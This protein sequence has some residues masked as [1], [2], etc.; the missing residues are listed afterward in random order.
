MIPKKII[1]NDYVFQNQY[2]I[3]GHYDF[4]INVEYENGKSDDIVRRYSDI[5]YLY[6]TLILKCPGCLIPNIPSKSIWLKINYGNNEQM[7]DRKEG[8]T[9][10]LTY[11]VNHKILKRNKYVINFFSKDYK[12]NDNS[13]NNNHSSNNN[14]DS[15]DDFDFNSNINNENNDDD[16]DKKE[17]NKNNSDDEDIEP[18]QEFI[19]EYNNRK[20]GIV[21]KGK[22]LIGNM[23]NYV[24]SYAG[25]SNNKENE[26]EK[27]N[28]KNN[29]NEQSNLFYKKLSKEDYDF[30]NKKSKELGE[31]FE[32]NEYNEKINRLN[33]GVKNIIQNLEKIS[34]I[35]DKNIHALENIVNNDNNY[36]NINREN[37]NIKISK[38][39]NIDT[40]DDKD[41]EE[42]CENCESYK[43]N[44]HK[45]N[46]NKIRQHCVIQRGFLNK[47]GPSITK[48]KKYQILLEGL[49]D[50]YSRKKEHINFLGRL[51]SQKEEMEKYKQNNGVMDP[52][53]KNK[54]DELENKII[55][56]IKFIKKINK[57]LKYEIERYKENQEDIYILINSLFKDKSNSI[58]SCLENLNKSNEEDFE[59]NVEKSNLNKDYIKEY[60][61]EKNEDE[62]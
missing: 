61:D 23:F 37:K 40:Y 53:S 30:I 21:S 58:K 44:N 19:E 18:S 59:V 62:F 2:Y 29:N 54:I 32:I 35:R 49:L 60:I 47:K 48:I 4:K 9:E 6:K 55:H 26:E 51:H 42:N 34:I 7:I 36:R 31:N 33:E 43:I 28:N 25:S 17:N 3:A 46:I 5:R 14:N 20:K 12:R 57:D 41:E 22:K 45:S 16:D 52:V 24:M 39:N 56:E 8:I 11:L 50:I 1:L 15:D 10:F 38:D 13:S 27:E